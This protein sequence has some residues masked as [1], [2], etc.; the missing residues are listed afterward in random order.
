VLWPGIASP[1]PRWGLGESV[2]H[3]GPATT[4]RRPPSGGPAPAGAARARSVSPASGDPPR[5]V[6]VRRRRFRRL[7][8]AADSLC[9]G[10]GRRGRMR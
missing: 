8:H 9:H 4:P 3:W 10:I 6:T 1:S 2:R 7:T 5:Q